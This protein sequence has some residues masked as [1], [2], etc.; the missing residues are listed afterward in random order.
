MYVCG[1]DAERQGKE[2]I[3]GEEWRRRDRERAERAMEKQAAPSRTAEEHW[4]PENFC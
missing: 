2:K 1:R 4:E 3:A